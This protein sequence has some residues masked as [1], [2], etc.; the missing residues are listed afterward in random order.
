MRHLI[1]TFVAVFTLGMAAQA[2]GTAKVDTDK[3]ILEWDAKKIGGGHNG[4]VGIQSGTLKLNKSEISGGSFVI[5]MNSIVCLDIENAEYNAKLIGHLKSD[6]FFST[7]K[8]PTA[9]L[10]IKKV[11][12]LKANSKG[13]THNIYA[14]LTIKGITNEIV[15]PASVVSENG[16]ITADASFT[17]DRAKYD[18]RYGSTSFFPNIG[19]KAIG[20]DMNFKVKIIA[21]Q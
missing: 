13:S 10:T 19:D 2:Q 6:D 1:M 12:R 11:V 15:F 9:T 8:F 17:V 21:K 4:T 16:V 5:D 7:E 20:N 14:D 3:S 18:V